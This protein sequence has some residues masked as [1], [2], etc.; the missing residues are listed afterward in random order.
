MTGL[1]EL[2]QLLLIMAFCFV[3]GSAFAA[4]GPTNP[5]SDLADPLRSFI[6][7]KWH[8]QEAQDYLQKKNYPAALAAFQ[9]AAYWANKTAQYNI[10]IMYLKGMEGIPVDQVRAVAWLGIAAQQHKPDVDKALHDAFVAL[11][12]EQNIAASALWK[13]LNADYG[14]DVTLPRATKRFNAH[15][16]SERGASATTDTD[17]SATTTSVDGYNH[18]SSGL[19]Q[20][21][22]ASATRQLINNLNSTGHLNHGATVA[23]YFTSIKQQFADYVT[24]QF[25][26]VDVGP[27]EAVPAPKSQ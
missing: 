10:G 11:T 3:G 7:G 13:Q 18:A 23:G 26:H 2:K 17:V 5:H 1:H 8:E 9:Q 22:E 12:P 4:A 16:A 19:G 6:P 27:V 20:S 25:G 24:V 15:L 21:G 14:D